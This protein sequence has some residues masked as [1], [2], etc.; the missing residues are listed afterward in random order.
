MALNKVDICNLALG[1]LAVRKN[2]QSFDERTNEAAACRMWYDLSLRELL[3]DFPWPF[4]TK[5]ELLAPLEFDG[6]AEWAYKYQYPADCAMAHRLVPS[7]GSVAH[8]FL[9]Q[10]QQTE[11]PTIPQ[12]TRLPFRVYGGSLYTNVSEA[13]LEYT[14]KNVTESMFTEDFVMAFASRLA[15]YLA[16]FVAGGDEFKLGPRSWELYKA[17]YMKGR[18]N[19]ANEGAEGDQPDASWIIARG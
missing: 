18:A 5:V 8:P 4:A 3:R 16:P 14:D 15:V 1:L 13:Q 7:Y 9:A 17:A 10:P 2:I 11:P 6:N 19:A 12:K